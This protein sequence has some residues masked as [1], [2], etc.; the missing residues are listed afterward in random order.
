MFS[1]KAWKYIAEGIE[2]Y[3][4]LFKKMAG[5]SIEEKDPYSD[6]TEVA[7]NKTIG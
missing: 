4:N 6:Y 7:K 5:S 1:L 3:A 2:D